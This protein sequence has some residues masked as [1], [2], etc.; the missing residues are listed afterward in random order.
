[1]RTGEI[2]ALTG[3][4]I[5]AAVWV[6]LFHFRPLLRLASPDLSDAL[7]PVLNCGAQGVDLFF[8]LSGFVLTWNYLERMGQTFSARATVHFLWLRLARVWPIYLVT[9]HLAL[10]WVIF[11]QHVG[12]VPP[13]DLSRLTATSYVRQVLLVQLWFEPFFDFTSW[14]GPAWSI[15]AEWLAY[16]L[17]GVLILVVYRMVRVTST[18]ALTALAIVASLPPLLLLLATGQFYTPWSWL[19]RIVMQF[20]A[21]ALACAAV[22]KMRPGPWTCRVAGLASV[23]LVA[24]M[25]GILY[26]FDAHPISGIYDSGGLVDVLF[27]PLVMTL[28]IG[29]G[30]LPWLLSTRLMVYG[31]QISFCLYMV[32]ELVH[33]AWNWAAVQF[34]IMLDEGSTAAGWTVGGLLAGATVLSMALFHGVEEPARHWMRRMVGARPQPVT[35]HVRGASP[36]DADPVAELLD[37]R[38][39]PVAVSVP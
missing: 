8:I 27:V 13:T 1:M 15:S 20:T 7:A 32:H 34:E 14:D 12:H 26:F 6:V 2:R 5:I 37:D 38:P 30:S 24:A 4:R 10:G 25:G 28:A 35:D 11:T 22:R 36:G 18:G 17:F 31:G 29:T 23:L 33:T 19:P 16:L 21:G 9:L 3:L 39:A